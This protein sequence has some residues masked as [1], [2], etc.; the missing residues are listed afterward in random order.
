MKLNYRPEIDGLRFVAVMSVVFY[1]AK[2][3]INNFLIFEGGYIGVDIFFVISGYLISFI[4]LTELKKKSK[5]NFL[6]FYDKRI[7][8]II[9]ALL[10]VMIVSFPFAW[11]YLLPGAFIEYSKSIL[12]SLGFSSNFFFLYTGQ[13]Y[14]ADSSLLK[15]FLHTWSLSVEEQFYILYPLF[16]YLIYKFFRKF[17]FVILTIVFFLSL[18]LAEWLSN[19]HPKINFYVFPTRAWELIAGALLAY[20]EVFNKKK[21]ILKKFH[22]LLLFLSFVILFFSLMFFDENTKHPSLIT[23]LPV[24][25]TCV[26][27]SIGNNKNLFIKLLSNKIFVGIGLISYSLYLWHFPIFSFARIIGLEE[28]N[29]L[30]KIGLIFLSIFLSAITYFFIEQPA[31]RKK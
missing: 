29:V 6:N 14:G 20:L 13:L 10:V 23:L 22:N 19:F 11:L 27:I 18:F 15:P 31:R 4:I 5:F 7:R 12:Y 1:H 30:L 26:I 9:P 3:Y 21:I 25:A 24:I 2:I 8:R 17:I 28:N 16:L